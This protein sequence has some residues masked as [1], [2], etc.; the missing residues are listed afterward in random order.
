M[1]QIE[2]IDELK[3]I[4]LNPNYLLQPDFDIGTITPSLMERLLN[5]LRIYNFGVTD[6]EVKSVAEIR[7]TEIN[8]IIQNE[9]LN[10]PFQIGLRIAN[11]DVYYRK[12]IEVEGNSV[13]NLNKLSM[14]IKERG[15][16]DDSTAGARWKIWM[17]KSGNSWRVTRILYAQLCARIG[18][19]H[20]AITC[21]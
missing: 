9:N 10:N 7:V 4:A 20:Y 13:E 11:D 15:Y 2:N 21:V 19:S 16:L 1:K 5:Y 18:S 14:V 8:E 17:E 12:S 3:K 6:V